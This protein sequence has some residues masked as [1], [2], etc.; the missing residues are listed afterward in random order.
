MRV[1]VTGHKGYIGTVMV[2]ML[3]QHG[4]TVVGIDSDLYRN[5]TYGTPPLPVEEII[6]DVR[7]IEPADLAG[8]EAVVSLAALSN[9]MLGDL[10]PDITYEVNHQASVRLAEM[11]KDLGISATYLP[12]RAAC[13][14]QLATMFWMRAPNSIRSRRTLHRKFG[15]N[16][17]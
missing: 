1:L 13:T 16:A 10:N 14:V 11:S 7:D 8:V 3:Q 17:T 6:K 15:L 12:H 9:D 4:H 5:S 2:P